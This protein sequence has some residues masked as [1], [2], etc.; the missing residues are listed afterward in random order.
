MVRQYLYRFCG[1]RFLV[2]YPD[3]SGGREY[4][5]A[6]LPFLFPSLLDGTTSEMHVGEL[7][8]WDS[9]YRHNAI[10]QRVPWSLLHNSV[11][12]ASRDPLS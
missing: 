8:G 10:Y 6:K 12:K 2:A 4:Q 9:L 5:F 7:D 11:S 3:G 1:L